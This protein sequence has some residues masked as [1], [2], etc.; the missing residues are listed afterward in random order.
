MYISNNLQLKFKKIVTN[1]SSIY[2]LKKK[3]NE[4]KLDKNYFFSP[5]LSHIIS[6]NIYS[7]KLKINSKKLDNMIIYSIK[8]YEEIEKEI[9][10]YYNIQKEWYSWHFPELSKIVTD[11]EMYSLLIKRIEKKENLHKIDI[12]DIVDDNI[13]KN[14]YQNLKISIGTKIHDD[15]LNAILILTDHIISMIRIKKMLNE[16]IKHRMYYSAPNLCS[17]IGEKI[18]SKLISAAGSLLNLSKLPASTIQIIGAEK[19]LYKALKTKGKTPKF[20]LIYNSR[21]IQKCSP[22]L[23][24]KISRILS[25]KTSICVRVDALGESNLGGCIGIKYREILENR[26]KQFDSFFNLSINIKK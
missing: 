2:N 9:F 1:K 16:Y 22:K 23:K 7:I 6:H 13:K 14:I 17:I 5:K 12:S 24:G 3:L 8:L 4:T 26:L 25:A 19:S 11:P 10:H 15:D 21:V 18:G 20:G